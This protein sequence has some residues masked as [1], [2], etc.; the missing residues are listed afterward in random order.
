MDVRLDFVDANQPSTS[1]QIKNMTERFEPLI[2]NKPMKKVSNLK[3]FFKSCLALIN[4]KDVV[5]E[6][7]ALI[8]ETTDDLQ[9]E[10]RFNHIG[11]RLKTGRELQMTA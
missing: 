4:D 6:L 2:T 10:K 5:T 3:E 7:T 11:K 8:E 9:P 1:R